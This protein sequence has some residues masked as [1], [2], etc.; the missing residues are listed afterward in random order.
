VPADLDGDGDLDV[1]VTTLSGPVRVF[2]NNAVASQSWLRVR[3][4]DPTGGNREGIGALVTA[5][6]SSGRKIARGLGVSG[7]VL[8]S[9]PAEVHFAPGADS[10]DAIDVTWPSGAVQHVEPIEPGKVLVVS[11]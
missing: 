1:L 2:R 7:V 3:L 11:P 4:D 6:L 10:I 5:T 8:A 9:G